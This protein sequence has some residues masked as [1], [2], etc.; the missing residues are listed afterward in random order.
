MAVEATGSSFARKNAI[1]YAVL[2]ILVGLYF[3]HD[4]WLGWFTDYMDKELEAGGDNPTLNLQFNRYVPF[5]LWP[6]ALYYLIQIPRISKQR[7]VADNKGLTIQNQPTLSYDT[8]THIDNRPFDKSGYFLVG[9]N[10]GGR[11]R[12][13]KFSDRKYDNLGLLLDELVKQTGAKPQSE[14]TSDSNAAT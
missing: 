7:L 9:V 4:G 10:D 1:I 11:K 2:G 3:F 14:L 5:V 12:E 8:I 6:F 13:L